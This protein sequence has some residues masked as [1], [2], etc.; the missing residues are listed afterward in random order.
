MMKHKK[1]VLGLAALTV[2]FSGCGK[3]DYN[4]TYEGYE[5]PTA[6]GTN[7]QMYG[8]NMVQPD[9]ATL[10]ISQNGE[11]V[12]GTYTTRS[13]IQGNFMAS[14]AS[15]NRL[16]NVRLTLP[17]F[18]T[19]RTRVSIT[20]VTTKVLTARACIKARSRQPMMLVAFKARSRS[21]V[22]TTT[23]P[24]ATRTTTACVRVRLSTFRRP[25]TANRSLSGID[26]SL[27]G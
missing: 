16:D 6:T 1:V 23:R 20:W 7:Q 21:T 15:S 25:T 18:K 14:A 5:T 26:S 4:G 12:S 22:P 24:Q 8:M 3:N 13:G 2:V 17:K 19:E 11:T 10:T 27:N 9:Y